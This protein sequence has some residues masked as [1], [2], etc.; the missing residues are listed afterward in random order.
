MRDIARFAL[1]AIHSIVVAAGVSAQ[2]A[3]EVP[4]EEQ[5]RSHIKQRL[6]YRFE[7]QAEFTVTE[8]E[9]IALQCPANIY[10]IEDFVIFL[11]GKG[12][13]WLW[14][15]GYSTSVQYRQLKGFVEQIGYAPCAAILQ[16]TV[17][18]RKL[19]IRFCITADLQKIAPA[20]ERARRERKDW[21]LSTK[22]NNLWLPV[23]IPETERI[24]GFARLWTEVKYNFAYFDKV[25]DLDW[26]KVLDQYLPRVQKATTAPEY[27]KV[28]RE[29]M[30]LLHD[31]HTDVGGPEGDPTAA[32]PVRVDA[33][34]GK[35]VIV[36]VM[37]PEKLHDPALRGELTAAGLKIGEE[38]TALDGQGVEEFMREK[39]FPYISASTTHDME[40]KACFRLLSGAPGSKVRLKVRSADGKQREVTLTRGYYIIR[41]ATLKPPADGELGDGIF[42]IELDSFQSP[43][44][45]DRFRG[46]LP[47]IHQAKGLILDVRRNNGGNSGYGDKIIGHLTD[48]KLKGLHLKTRVYRPAFRAWGQPE[49]WHEENHFVEPAED[50]YLGP[51]VVLT[52]VVTGSAA[53]DFA[54]VL[55]V[56]GRATLVGERTAGTSGQPLM[57]NNVPGG[58]S[59]R[60]VTL[61]DLSPDGKEFIG[62]GVIPHVEAH[63]TAVDVAAGRDVVLDAGLATLTKIIADR[64]AD[65]RAI[66]AR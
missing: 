48:K 36:A 34:Q 14:Y 47:K 35:I 61:Q 23:A 30:A 6:P 52:S 43:S 64:L 39:L 50:R 5:I 40:R 38:I 3:P 22:A 66:P 63:P 15:C 11:D 44:I 21:G 27:Y 28:L 29:C 45:V 53:E 51:V 9:A 17:E 62:V 37:A 59:A 7:E 26:D 10:G 33:F 41:R 56:N 1:L 8:G 55:R 18:G 58:G 19:N 65:A 25:P 54:N 46:H 49:T 13:G 16:W 24:A 42:Y 12:L 60:I 20:A 32:P 4:S 2:R 31:G 57:I